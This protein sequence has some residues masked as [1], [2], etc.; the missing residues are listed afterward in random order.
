M[1]HCVTYLLALLSLLFHASPYLTME[2]RVM[3]QTFSDFSVSYET[4]KPPQH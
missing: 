1:T 4:T 2:G 3:T